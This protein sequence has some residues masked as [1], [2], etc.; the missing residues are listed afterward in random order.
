MF[1]RFITQNK[2]LSGILIVGILLLL[3]LAWPC[4]TWLI[5]RSLYGSWFGPSAATDLND[6]SSDVLIIYKAGSDSYLDAYQNYRQSYLLNASVK[7]VNDQEAASEDFSS[8]ELIYLER[9]LAT[10]DRLEDIEVKVKTY[11]WQGGTVFLENAL[12]GALSSSVSGLEQIDYLD[13]AWYDF[14]YPA[15]NQDCAQV[16]VVAGELIKNFRAYRGPDFAYLLKKTARIKNNAVPIVSMGENAVLWYNPYGEGRVFASSDFMPCTRVGTGFDLQNRGSDAAYFDYTLATANYYVRNEILAAADKSKYG[17]ALKK[18]FGPYGRPAMAWQNHLEEINAISRGEPLQ[19]LAMLKEH[20]QVPSISLLSAPFTWSQK[21]AGIN[22]L[23]NIGNDGSPVFTGRELDSFYSNGISVCLESTGKYLDVGAYPE[24]TTLRQKLPSAFRAYPSALEIGGQSEGMLVGAP[25]GSIYTLANLST[26]SHIAFDRLE[27]C[28]LAN[29]KQAAVSGHAAPVQY[30]V[31]R[32]GAWDLLSGSEDGCIYYFRNSGSAEQPV[33]EDA[34]L[35]KDAAGSEI[36]VSGDAA[37]AMGDLDGDGTPDL[38]VGGRQG[39]LQAYFGQASGGFEAG[40]LSVK[41]QDIIKAY[42]APAIY[43]WNRDGR[44]DI[45]AGDESGRVRIFLNTGEEFT[46]DG[47]IEGQTTNFQGD[48]AVYGIQNSV[49]LMMDL[50]GDQK[51]DLLIG[52]VNTGYSMRIDSPQFP[53][54]EAIKALAAEL[55]QKG[56]DLD[57]HF[58]TQKHLSPEQERQELSRSKQAFAEYGIDFKNAGLTQ[59]TWAIN[60]DDPHQSFE[61]AMQEGF[62]YN[63]GFNPLYDIQS[64]D[65]DMQGIDKNNIGQPSFSRQFI[66]STPF[67]LSDG[68]KTVDFLLFNPAPYILNYR[69]A[70][71]SMQNLDMPMTQFNHFER[72]AVNPEIMDK[73]EKIITALDEVRADGEY[74]FMTERQMAKSFMNMFYSR[75]VVEIKGDRLIISPDISAVPELAGEYRNTLGIKIETGEKYKDKQPSTSSAIYYRKGTALYSGLPGPTEIEL[76]AG[77]VEGFHLVRAN[78]PV[79]ISGGSNGDWE[80]LTEA[81]GMQQIKIFSPQ[82]PQIDGPDLI[83]RDEGQ[84]YYSITHFGDIV[85]ISI[86]T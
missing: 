62:W 19:W 83:I 36:K 1:S 64:D 74:N 33:F 20:E 18:T 52:Q 76:A 22:V 35:F 72:F 40:D 44:M 81:R 3:Y 42:A 25:D 38:L 23:Q 29:G 63:F 11:L 2:L 34:V 68:E 13:S 32:D 45:L 71:D 86:D 6:Y 17:F 73:L 66:W 12:E 7:A 46:Y 16:Q 49:P 28:R 27:L 67:L 30:D 5:D 37:P 80:V 57:L 43:D 69:E 48:Q 24:E 31:D 9:S 84:G 82:T 21:Y 15:V 8:Y 50:N 70:C 56:L 4:M 47:D 51:D 41:G 75:A 14:Q 59:H 65:I 85:S 54:R 78:V 61:S 60:V 79:R 10:S 26:G 55:D 39:E 77:A 53:C 58:Y